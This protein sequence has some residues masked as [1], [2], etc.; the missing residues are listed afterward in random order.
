MP[1]VTRR[2]DGQIDAL[3]GDA[4]SAT[5]EYLSVE[6]PDVQAFLGARE[7][8]ESFGRLDAEFVRVIEDV[9]TR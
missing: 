8:G 6:H 5:A 3:H 7:P 2:A 4:P 9:S 1:Y